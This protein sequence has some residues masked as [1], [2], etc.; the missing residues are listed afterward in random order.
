[1]SLQA[2]SS[3]PHSLLGR[4]VEIIGDYGTVRSLSDEDK[5]SLLPAGGDVKGHRAQVL[6]WAPDDREKYLVRTFSDVL[7]LVAPDA[8]REFTPKSGED[9]DFDVAWPDQGREEAFSKEVA[10]HLLQKGFCVVQCF[11]QPQ[12]QHAARASAQQ[13]TGWKRLIKELEPAYLG[14][15]PLGK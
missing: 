8:L 4:F 15:E 3:S 13:Q 2:A 12:V 10:S 5:L 6:G 9:G 14:R 7:V 1:M 11:L